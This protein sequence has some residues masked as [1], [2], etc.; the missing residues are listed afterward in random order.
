MSTSATGT[1]ASTSTSTTST[2]RPRASAK[3]VPFDSDEVQVSGSTRFNRLGLTAIGLYRTFRFEDVDHRRG[4]AVHLEQQLRHGD[5]RLVGASYAFTPGRFVTATVRL[6]DIAY[7]KSISRGRDSF[8]WVALLG[9]EYDF[10]G[11]WA[12]RIGV[13]YQQ[14]EYNSP[15]IKTL[16]GPALEGR[17]SWSP[18]QLTTVTFNVARTHRGVD[19]AGR[20]Q[21]PD[22]PP[23]ASGWT[24]STCATCSSA[25]RSVPTAASTAGH[26][27]PAPRTAWSSSTVGGSS[28]GACRSSAP[29]P[30]P[31]ASKP[32]GRSTTYDRHLVQLRLRVAL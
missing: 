22:G 14:R 26:E 3:P 5:R 11:V 23:A 31:R 10:D 2:C 32:V 4:E 9:F 20:G 12:G 7:E 16:E 18:T 17:L 27:A 13:G 15:Q 21:L 29:T 28:T 19:P 6:Q 1:T 8:T 30:T 24:M 25:A